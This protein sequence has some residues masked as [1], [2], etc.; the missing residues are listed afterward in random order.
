MSPYISRGVISIPQVFTQIKSQDIPWSV[1]EKFF[2]ELAWREYWQQV[3]ISKGD[4]IHHDLKQEQKPI[5]NLKIPTALCQA[6]T[7]ILAIDEA[8]NELH[9]TGYMHNHMRMYVAS[10]AC[11]I[12]QSHWRE[13][14]RW[15]YSKLLDGDLASN[16]LSWQWVAGAF[17][18]K[19]YV[20]NQENINT[21]FNS[22]QINTFL[23]VSYEDLQKLEIPQVLK[24]LSAFE[25]TTPLPESSEALELKNKSTLIYNYYNLDP[26]WHKEKDLQRILLLEPSVFKRHPISKRAVDFMLD[27]SKNIPHIQVYVGEFESLLAFV[28]AENIS[29]KEHPLNSH[30]QGIEEP[31]AWLSTVTGYFPSFFAFWKKCKKEI[32]Y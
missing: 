18:K 27:L 17:S 29:Y 12:A 30:Y 25:L 19:K 24:E 7:G 23:D 11:N 28:E 31:R 1:G 6:K 3:W 4:D 8:I 15:M 22:D 14:A 5:N 32:Q 2:Q 16:H 9:E 13:P 20:A 10:M 26:N 21:F